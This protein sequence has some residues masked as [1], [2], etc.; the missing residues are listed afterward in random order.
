MKRQ[1]NVQQ[2]KGGHITGK[3]T[4]KS[5]IQIIMFNIY[6]THCRASITVICIMKFKSFISS[7][8]GTQIKH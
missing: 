3:N 4:F 6:H 7:F 2:Q 1:I 5:H 8:L